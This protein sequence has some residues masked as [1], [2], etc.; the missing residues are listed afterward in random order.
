MRPRAILGSMDNH[1]QDQ[2]ESDRG[3]LFKAARLRAGFGQRI[4]ATPYSFN[5]NH[6]KFA[7]KV[8]PSATQRLPFV[9]PGL[10]QMIRAHSPSAAAGILALAVTSR[11]RHEL[12][13]LRATTD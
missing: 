3:S 7:A 5:D 9:T 4:A 1:R 10:R 12:A 13:V 2:G 6:V 8:L 11:T